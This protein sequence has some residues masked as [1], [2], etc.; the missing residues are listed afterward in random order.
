MT[1]AELEEYERK[2]LYCM[3]REAGFKD[4]I[5]LL[6]FAEVHNITDSRDLLTVIHKMSIR[7]SYERIQS[8]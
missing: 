1:I 2:A 3:A 5:E 8:R 4:K 7:R 6:R